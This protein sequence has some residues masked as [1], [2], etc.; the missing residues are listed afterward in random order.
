VHRRGLG[1]RF[2]GA[3]SLLLAD[4]FQAVQENADQRLYRRP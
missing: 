1:S 3:E 4:G 2:E